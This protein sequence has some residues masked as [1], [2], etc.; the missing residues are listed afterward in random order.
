MVEY[1]ERALG[2]F[3]NDFL[4]PSHTRR[5]TFFLFVIHRNVKQEGTA[6]SLDQVSTSNIH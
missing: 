4:P 5:K 6:I 2:H 3:V 1:N